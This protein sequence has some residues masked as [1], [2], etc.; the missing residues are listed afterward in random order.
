MN[1]ILKTFGYLVILYV[2]FWIFYILFVF[3]KKYI[4][5]KYGYPRLF[6]FLED[7]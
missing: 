3:L 1:P 2:F 7:K 6:K 5:D 4:L